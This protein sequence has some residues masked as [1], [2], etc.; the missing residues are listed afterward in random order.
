MVPGTPGCG[1]RGWPP[2]P[3]RWGGGG[4]RSR[5]SRWPAPGR[6]QGEPPVL[7]VQAQEPGRR[8]RDADDRVAVAGLGAP[9]PGRR[10]R[11]PPWWRR[12]P[13]WSRRAGGPGSGSAPRCCSWWAPPPQWRRPWPPPRPRRCRPAPAC[14]RPPPS[15]AGCA[16]ATAPVVGAGDLEDRLGGGGGGAQEEAGQGRPREGQGDGRG[17][18]EDAGQG[19]GQG[20]GRGDGRP[21]PAGLGGYE[22]AHASNWWASPGRGNGGREPTAR[23][24]RR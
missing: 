22:F 23:C 24:P 1:R 11:A 2:G 3:P 4:S 12:C 8:P 14:A 15:P 5:R 20:G 16:E 10:W 19:G 13:G 9:Y 18:G 7:A 21:G 6:G 17:Q